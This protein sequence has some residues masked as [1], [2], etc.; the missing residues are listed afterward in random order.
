MSQESK[1]APALAALE[2][3][4]DFRKFWMDGRLYS[5]SGMDKYFWHSIYNA[6]FRKYQI[7]ALNPKVASVLLSKKGA[8]SVL[9]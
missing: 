7:G 8:I 9:T 5:T 2:A 6:I 4:L 1:K 3:F